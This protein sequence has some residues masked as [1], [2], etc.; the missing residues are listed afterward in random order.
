MRIGCFSIVLFAAIHATY[1]AEAQGINNSPDVLRLIRSAETVY[2]FPVTSPLKPQ[3]DDRHMRL[4][5]PEARKD[6]V[7]LLGNEGSW[8]H[9]LAAIAIPEPQQTNIGLL[10]RSG[11]DEVVLFFNSETVEGKFRE[12]ELGGLLEKKPKAEFEDWKRHYAQPELAFK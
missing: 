3:R 9:G 12:I 4:L 7:Q 5:G 1:G 8:W 2:V 6:I 11:K 10:F